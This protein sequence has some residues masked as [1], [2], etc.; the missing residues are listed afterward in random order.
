MASGEGEAT[1]AIS[2][3]DI[4]GWVSLERGEIDRRIYSDDEIFELEMERIFGRAWLFL[5]HESQIPNSGD[6]FQSVMGR[7]NVLVVRQKD[8]GVRAVLNTCP[9]RGNAVCRADEGNARSFLCTYHGWSFGIDGALKGVPGFKNFY[10]G[11]LDKSEHGLPPVAQ[12]TSYKGFVFGTHDATAPPLEEYLG[13]TGRLGLDL[14]ACKGDMEIVPGIQKF[15]LDCNWKFAVDNLFDWYHPQLTHASAFA[16]NVRGAV[17][18]SV[19]APG[20]G[21]VIDMSGV[22]QQ[23]GSELELATA[24]ISNTAFDN[25]VVIGEYGHAIGGPTTA[26]RGNEEVPPRWRAA[27]GVADALGPAGIDVAGHP[28]IFPTS[29]VTTTMQLSLRI[30]RS[31]SRTEIWWFS[32]VPRELPPEF[33]K[34][35]V[36]IQNHLFGPAGLLEQED[37]ENWNQATLQTHGLASR[38]TKHLL[39]MGLGRGKVIKEHG[40]ARIETLTNEHAQLWTYHAWAQWMKGLDWPELRGMT[41]PPDVL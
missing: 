37:G 26:S 22:E 16:P 40:L 36:R 23:D 9:H 7:D 10:S 17:S 31:P 1:V 39:N 41:T 2:R 13:A 34:V 12:V 14:L 5:C 15:V 32:F 30:P 27:P 19:A 24:A 4:D 20:D 38:R 6:F 35:V 21:P 28:S 25:V 29:W 33:R 8:G 11:E 3:D 18:G